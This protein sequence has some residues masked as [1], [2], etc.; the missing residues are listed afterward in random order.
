[1][2][3][4]IIADE[5]IEIHNEYKEIENR[6]KT[7]RIDMYNAFLEY[8]EEKIELDNNTI[9][10]V[11]EREQLRIVNREKLLNILSDKIDDV[12]LIGDIL[13]EVIY[14]SRLNSGI[15]IIKKL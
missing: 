2:S 14:D 9:F 10:K 5:L 12:A 3:L 13:S 7:K 11:P 8:D 4:K 1:M 6:L 15:R